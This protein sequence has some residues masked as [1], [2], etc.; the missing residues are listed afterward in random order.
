MTSVLENEYMEPDRPYSQNEL[1]FNRERLRRDLRLSKHRAYHERCQH[2]YLVRV[3]GRKE[4]E[5]IE[6]KSEDVG[7]CSVCWTLSKTQRNLKG[8]AEDLVDH[9]TQ[10]FETPIKILTYELNDVESTF[11]IWLYV[12]TQERRGDRDRRRFRERQ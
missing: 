6:T 7:N 10:T 11:Y 4:R 1:K 9:Y 5:M 2:H 8:R 12:D 3:N